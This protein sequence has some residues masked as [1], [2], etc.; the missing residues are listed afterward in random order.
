[1]ARMHQKIQPKMKKEIKVDQGEQRK[2]KRARGMQSKD[3]GRQGFQSGRINFTWCTHPST[4]PR[5]SLHHHSSPGVLQ[6]L[7]SIWWGWC[8]VICANMSSQSENHQV[9]SFIN[10]W[11][12]WA[13]LQSVIIWGI[14]VDIIC[15]IYLS[16][17]T[18]R[19]LCNIAWDAS[20]DKKNIARIANA[21]PCHS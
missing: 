13:K 15:T 19:Y 21:V 8:K 20:Q 17:T 3:W 1:M 2:E 11:M 10:S 14:A 12:I 18:V 5:A 4:L 6:I 9:L 7:L 16:Q